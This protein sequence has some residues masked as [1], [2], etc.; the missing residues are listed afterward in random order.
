MSY[1]RDIYES[2]A[3]L[4]QMFIVTLKLSISCSCN[5]RLC[6]ADIFPGHH[7]ADAIAEKLAEQYDISME[8]VSDI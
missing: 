6:L 8:Y 1:H 5:L 7:T 2:L 3:Q 4:V